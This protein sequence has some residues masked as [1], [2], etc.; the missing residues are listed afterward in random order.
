MTEWQSLKPENGLLSDSAIVALILPSS[1]LVITTLL[2]NQSPWYV[3]ALILLLDFS[4]CAL[5]VLMAYYL[6]RVLRYRISEAAIEVRGVRKWLAY[7]KQSIQVVKIEAVNIN[8]YWGVRIGLAGFSGMAHGRY[9]TEAGFVQFHGY[10]GAAE[11][12]VLVRETGEAVVMT[13]QNLEEFLVRLLELG[14]PLSQSH[15]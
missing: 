4:I 15:F 7:E 11:S 6:N 9:Q 3:I 13:P 1:V 2:F 8:L 14:Y 5:F 10:T 12:V